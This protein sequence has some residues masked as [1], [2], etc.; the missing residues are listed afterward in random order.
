MQIPGQPSN[1]FLSRK[2]RNAL[3]LTENKSFF[4]KSSQKVIKICKKIK[5]LKQ[6]ETKKSLKTILIKNILGGPEY[7]TC[8]WELTLGTKIIKKIRFY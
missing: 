4:K 1:I 8:V 6:L 3:N 2:N 7:T 5:E